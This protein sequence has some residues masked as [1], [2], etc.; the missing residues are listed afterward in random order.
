M[1]VPRGCEWV[2]LAFYVQANHL[3]LE[4]SG[5]RTIVSNLVLVE[6]SA[7]PL[8]GHVGGPYASD[9]EAGLFG[10][11]E[12]SVP[13]RLVHLLYR[14]VVSMVNDRLS[15]ACLVTF[16]IPLA[17]AAIMVM[18]PSFGER[19]FRGMYCLIERLRTTSCRCLVA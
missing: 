16:G 18:S 2:P 4:V 19:L 8:V 9:A 11:G 13:Q 12:H 3:E 15:E 5:Y 6:H 7:C 17:P 14:F 10:E 1:V